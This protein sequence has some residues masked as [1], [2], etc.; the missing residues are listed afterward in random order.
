MYRSRNYSCFFSQFLNNEDQI[1]SNHRGHG[2]FL[3]FHENKFKELLLEIMGKSG[4][5]LSGK[6]GYNIFIIKIFS[7]GILAGMFPIS[8]GSGFSNKIEINK[9]FLYHT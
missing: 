8:A 7:N 6:G 3:A 9:I 1:F 5:L 4:A 2:H